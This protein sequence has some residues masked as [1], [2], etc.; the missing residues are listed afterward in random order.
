MKAAAETAPRELRSMEVDIPLQRRPEGCAV[1]LTAG[2]RRRFTLLQGEPKAREPRMVAASSRISGPLSVE[3]LHRSLQAIAERHEALRTRIT[4]VDGVP[5]QRVDDAYQCPFDIVDVSPIPMLS[6]EQ[7]ALRLAQAFVDEPVDLCVGPLFQAKLFRLSAELHL[8]L[9]LIHHIISDGVSYAIL[10]RELWTTYR[11]ALGGSPMSLPPLPIQFADYAV[12]QERNYPTWVRKHASHWN[13]HLAGARRVHFPRHARSHRSTYPAVALLTLPFGKALTEELAGMARRERTLLSI[14]L[15]ATHIAVVSRWCNQDDVVVAF[16]S[17]GR[18]GRAELQNIV[19]CI[20]NLLHLRVR[21]SK[22]VT[23]ADLLK[24]VSI[25]LH[26]A[27]QHADDD[28]VLELI[29]DCPSELHFNW[30]P[31]NWATPS[32]QSTTDTDT[33]IDMQ[34]IPIQP[35]NPRANSAFELLVAPIT[36]P[37]GIVNHLWYRTDVLSASE[38]EQFGRNLSGFATQFS[39]DALMRVSSCTL[40]P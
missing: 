23:F 5:A 8:L 6:R 27:Y 13:E 37:L 26:R 9:I 36:S 10:N 29:P 15:L 20:A 40:L 11:Q 21:I 18:L 28:R 7:E 32:L 35:S 17:H 22:K 19:G 31:S 33:S 12:W 30:V 3:T 2:Q 1:P 4:L 34:P 16:V 24:H 38:V 14:V 39:R 25:E